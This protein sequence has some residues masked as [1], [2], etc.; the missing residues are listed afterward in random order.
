M[1]LSVAIFVVYGMIYLWLN[2]LDP[3]VRMAKR[4]KAAPFGGVPEINKAP[5]P[6]PPVQPINFATLADKMD[7]S[8]PKEQLAMMQQLIR[9]DPKNASAEEVK[10]AAKTMKKLAF[11]KNA[12]LAIRQNAVKAMVV[13]G[14]S[15]SVPQLMEL[16]KRGD[17]LDDCCFQSLV[18]LNDPRALDAVAEFYMTDN[19]GGHLAEYCLQA[20]GEAAEDAVLKYFPPKDGLRLRNSIDF[21]EKN[22]TT[23]SLAALEKVGKQRLYKEYAAAAI[24]AIKVRE[25]EKAKAKQAK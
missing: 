8:G 12:G 17:A 25:K 6:P 21:L 4:D 16:I 14:G 22:G 18:S 20:Y 23:K 10:I 7:V 19:R 11:D 5:A 9:M 1:G 24:A 13:W 3:N 2:S 15:Y